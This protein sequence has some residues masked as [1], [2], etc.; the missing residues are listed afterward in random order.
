[1]TLLTAV[2]WVLIFIN[3]GLAADIKIIGLPYWPNEEYAL[4]CNGLYLDSSKF[5]CSAC[6]ANQIVDVSTLAGDGNYAGC[7][8]QPGFVNV[9][10]DCSAVSE[11][12]FCFAETTIRHNVFLL[13]L[14]IQN[15]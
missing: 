6:P 1:M 3:C 4:P 13:C 10:N 12:S 11:L 9:L 7:T 5:M 15:V 14:Q 2:S 8:C